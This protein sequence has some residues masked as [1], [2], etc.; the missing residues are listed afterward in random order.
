MGKTT[1][2]AGMQIEPHILDKE[3]NLARSLDLIEA[4]ARQGTQLVVFPEAALTG[5]VYNS[6]E[7]A[8]PV[9][10]TIPG[11]STIRIMD[12]CREANIYAIIGL[13]EE[14]GGKY[15]NAAAF[16]G[17]SGLIGKYRKLHLP[18]LG[19][20]RFLNHGDLPLQVYDTDIGKIG[21]GICYDAAF[22]E[23]PR[24]LTLMGAEV[25]VI[26]TN[27][28]EGLDFVPEKE[29]PTRAR[30]NRVYFVVI[31]RVGEERGV[32]FLG[33]SGIYDC[34][35]RII[36]EGKPYEEELLYTDIN[37]NLAREKLQTLSP[38]EFEFDILKDRRPEFYQ[39]LT[40]PLEDNS[41]IRK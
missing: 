16:I 34:S 15:Y 18:Y 19:I 12:C 24:A 40:L 32:K 25:I 17:P 39:M 29:I 6:L 8:Y 33:R 27:W 26:I 9:M 5:Y 30:E 7:E 37:P 41:R 23:Y 31:D 4:A 13:L 38:G 22:P 10:E 1:K 28:T 21:I 11:P 35:G 14:D 2:I 3:R 20:D 36:V